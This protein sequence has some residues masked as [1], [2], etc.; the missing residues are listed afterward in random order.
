MSGYDAVLADP[1]IH[2]VYVPLPHNLHAEWTIKALQAGKHVLTEKPIAMQSADFD[3]MI[4]ARDASGCLAAEAY[5]I[6]HHPQWHRVKALIADGAIGDVHRVHTVFSY[7]NSDDVNNIRNQPDCGGGLRDIGCYTLGCARY[8]LG[9]DITDITAQIRLDQGVDTYCAAMGQIADAQFSMYTSTRMHLHQEVT[10]HGRLGLIRLTAPFNQG[11]F[12]QASIELHQP[13]LGL[14]VERFPMENQ[15]VRQ[16][17]TFAK[18]AV[19]GTPYPWTLE[20]ARGT[21]DAID[22]IFACATPV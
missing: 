8:V 21:Q 6:V 10:F 15:Y 16:V 1:D 18:S 4:A 12:N 2:A 11:G 17:E 9:A 5:M 3:A 20:Q 7:D 19:Q 22:T 14:R 13:N